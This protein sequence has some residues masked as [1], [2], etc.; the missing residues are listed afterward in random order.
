MSKFFQ[1]D[2]SGSSESEYESS[3]EEEEI[4]TYQ[5]EQ[6]VSR[7]RKWEIGNGDSD[8]ES[9]T[10][11]KTLKSKKDKQLEDLRKL[12]ESMLEMMEFDDWIKVSDDID[13]LNRMLENYKE[14]V[15]RF[16]IR[17]ISKMEDELLEADKDKEFTKQMNSSTAKAFNAVKQKIK[18]EVVKREQNLTQFR[19]NPVDEDQSEEEHE[20]EQQDSKPV[21]FLEVVKEKE[22][23]V[24]EQLEIILE[25]RG[26]RNTD[27]ISQIQLL[28][29]LKDLDGSKFQRVVV[30]NA[31]VPARI[32]AATRT[33][34]MWTNLLQEITQ[35]Y[36]LL[37]SMKNV[38]LGA[39]DDESTFIEKDK[40]FDQGKVVKL[41][42]SPATYVDRLDDEFFKS[43]QNM[44]EN[45]SEYT[46]RFGKEPEIYSLI[47]RAYQYANENHATSEVLD[48]LLMRRIEHIYYKS[49]VQ[50]DSIE[51]NLMSNYSGLKDLSGPSGKVCL[52]FCTKLFSSKV[53]RF[54]GRALLCLIYNLA[55]NDYYQEAKNYIAIT[56]LQDF[57]A[58][59]DVPT[60]AL[61][62]RT[63]VAVG[64]S[65]FRAG[66]F[67]DSH[68]FLL[69]IYSSGKMK[70]L[71]AQGISQ[72]QK[73]PTERTADQEKLDRSRQL[74][75][76][77]HLDLELVESVFLVSAMLLE[78]PNT[79]ATSF[80][81]KKKIISKNF[82]KR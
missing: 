42:G 79:A 67:H 2:V 36:D 13:K 26:K 31:L 53:E 47:V 54:R 64:L 70:E 46:E 65:A 30:L 25:N 28:E 75:Y 55:N 80:D 77:M 73:Y 4:Q 41:R 8:S 39:G 61:Y 44:D 5:P 9:D 49:N 66:K 14:E 51:K 3:S 40:L 29:Q 16:Y 10:D 33:L 71:L 17:S 24:F 43:L 20:N 15:P 12:S 60:Q 11:R 68:N 58:Q 1:N 81:S 72:Q 78:I 35:L 48:S 32:D 69:D 27:K 18:K 56:N 62:N 7:R 59:A 23:T 21:R 38:H 57:I 50:I 82:R 34:D 63:L 76:H 52:E 22:L 37:E 45:S 19:A 6:G 74:P